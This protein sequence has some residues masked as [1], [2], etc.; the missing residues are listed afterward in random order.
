ML[1]EQIMHVMYI[2]QQQK[3]KFPSI[4]LRSCDIMITILFSTQ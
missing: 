4:D 1:P 3:M 2:V